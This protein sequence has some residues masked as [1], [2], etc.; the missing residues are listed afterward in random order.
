[1]EID[2]KKMLLNVDEKTRTVLDEFE[3]KVKG[4]AKVQAA[5]DTGDVN[6]KSQI[7]LLL[8]KREAEMKASGEW[9]GKGKYVLPR[10]SRAF[11]G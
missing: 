8:E 10:R 4:L 9:E 11:I 6:L 3:K 2:G 7:K 1:M 5:S